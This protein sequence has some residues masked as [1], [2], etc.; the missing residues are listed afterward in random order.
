M[1]E[2]TNTLINTN[3]I[4]LA[5]TINIWYNVLNMLCI[6]IKYF[7]NINLISIKY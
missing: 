7:K 6:Y 1:Y 4:V 2:N 3:M 5:I